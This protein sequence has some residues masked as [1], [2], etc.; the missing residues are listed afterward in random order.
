[1]SQHAKKDLIRP[2]KSRDELLPDFKNALR[3]MASSVCII[4]TIDAFGAPHGMAASSV[5]SLSFDPLSMLISVNQSASICERLKST[6]AFCINVLTNDHGHYVESFSNPALREKRFESND[7]ELGT[8]GMPYLKTAQA[9]IFCEED[10]LLTYGTHTLFVGKVI[11]IQTQ[12]STG[13]F[14]WHNGG[15]AQIRSIE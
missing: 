9:A 14:V 5:V 12:H 3:G 2:F 6:K 8:L 13:P 7:W 10:G 15:R 11:D 4:T 1:M